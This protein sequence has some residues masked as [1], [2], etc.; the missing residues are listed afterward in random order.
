M[1]IDNSRTFRLTFPS[2]CRM[3]IRKLLAAG[4]Y[5][6]VSPDLTD[7][8][9][10]PKQHGTTKVHLEL[11]TFGLDRVVSN[12]DA[13]IELRRRRIT[14]A[15]IEHLLALG[16]THPGEQRKYPIVALGSIATIHDYRCVPFLAM[17]GS[18]RFARILALEDEW[19][20]P[21]HFL[22]IHE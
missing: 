12:S 8:H 15:S 18:S 2:N 7:E 3:M 6:W 21:M 4:K 1:H 14:P 17:D 5:D 20:S 9:F 16:E 10:P 11:L 13:Q 19:S 22:V